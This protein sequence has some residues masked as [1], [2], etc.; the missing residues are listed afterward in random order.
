MGGGKGQSVM[1]VLWNTVI[2]IGT[3]MLTKSF[4]KFLQFSYFYHFCQRDINV[5][6]ICNLVIEYIAGHI[7]QNTN[8]VNIQHLYVWHC[9]HRL[10]VL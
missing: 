2:F 1:D 9:I 8:K 5:C 7:S 4:A 6:Q 3:K 10:D